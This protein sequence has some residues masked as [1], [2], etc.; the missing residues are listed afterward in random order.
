MQNT[1]DG[2][3]T[4]QLA[5]QLTGINSGVQNLSTQLCNCC[6]DV[7]SNLCNGF[8]GVNA[9]VNAGFANAETSANARQMA[10]MQQAFNNQL[11]TIQGFNGVNSALCDASAENRLG[12]AN[13]TSTIL[14]ENCAD[15]AAL[16]EGVRDIITNQTANTQRIIDEIFRDRLDEKDSKISD[17][18]RE[19]QMADL[20]ASQIAQTQAITQNIYN[21]LKNCPVG[22]VPVYGNQPIFTCPNNNGCGCGNAFGSTIV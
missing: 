8:A 7:N 15:R 4:L 13:L 6:A 20:R 11:S 3:N 9:T 2:F 16:Q 5:N 12:Q 22:T 17:L 18:Q 10:N 21:E 19:L 14:A 1:N